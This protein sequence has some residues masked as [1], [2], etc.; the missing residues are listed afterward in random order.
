LERREGVTVQYRVKKAGAHK[1]DEAGA[2]EGLEGE[3][4]GG[5]GKEG[6]EGGAIGVVKG[7]EERA[8]RK[9]GSSGVMTLRRMKE[10]LRN[11]LWP[12]TRARGPVSHGPPVDASPSRVQPKRTASLPSDTLLLH[13][14]MPAVPVTEQPLTGMR[15]A[16]ILSHPLPPPPAAAELSPLD[17]AAAPLPHSSDSDMSLRYKHTGEEGPVE[18]EL[19]RL[20]IASVNPDTEVGGA[21]GGREGKEEEEQE[22]RDKRNQGL[23]MIAPDW[24]EVERQHKAKGKGVLIGGPA[25]AVRKEEGGVEGGEGQGEGGREEETEILLSPPRRIGG[26]R[27]KGGEL[28]HSPPPSPV[29]PAPV[30]PSLVSPSPISPPHPGSSAGKKSAR[31]LLKLPFLS[32]PAPAPAAAG[33]AAS[34]CRT[35]PPRLDLS[36][37]PPSP[38]AEAAEQLRERAR[39]MGIRRQAEKGEGGLGKREEVQVEGVLTDAEG[40]KMRAMQNTVHTPTRDLRGRAS[41]IGRQG[42]GDQSEEQVVVGP[43][44]SGK[45][46]KQMEGTQQMVKSASWE[47][48][49]D[50][51]E[52][53][54]E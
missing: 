51:Q 50:A 53:S 49:W 11:A 39:R 23:K 42:E 13:H 2:D 19:H 37:A 40:E 1:E 25:S 8:G 36:A 48:K 34:A 28:P 47:L 31:P 9:G 16:A 6:K 32:P 15:Q 41:S 17:L 46:L 22:R 26:N 4:A 45:E 52:L 20:G 12:P 33:G 7:E 38:A 44:L 5:E 24:E 43:L 29:S 27:G 54:E 21:G 35:P 10:A 3:E 18:H 30:A 14:G